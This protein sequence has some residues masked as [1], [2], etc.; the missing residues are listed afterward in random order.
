MC[1]PGLPPHTRVRIPAWFTPL[2][3]SWTSPE[4]LPLSATRRVLQW[5]LAPFVTFL[6]SRSAGPSTWSAGAPSNEC[7]LIVWFVLNRLK[8]RM[9]RCVATRVCARHVRATSAAVPYAG[10]RSPTARCAAFTHRC[11]RYAPACCFQHA[12]G[13]RLRCINI[14]IHLHLSCVCV[15]VCVYALL[16]VPMPASR[17]AYPHIRTSA[18]PHGRTAA[19]PHTCTG[20]YSPPHN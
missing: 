9:H 5:A 14:F 8:R 16:V 13:A 18:H 10:N 11:E 1:T 7:G 19:R 6:G 15:C 17:A 20:G 3:V 12:G 4:I 2:R